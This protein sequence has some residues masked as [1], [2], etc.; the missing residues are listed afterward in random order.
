MRKSSFLDHIKRR[1]D[2]RQY[3]VISAIIYFNMDKIQKKWN[4]HEWKTFITCSWNENEKIPLVASHP[5]KN[6]V[7]FVSVTCWNIFSPQ[8]HC[9]DIAV[10][11]VSTRNVVLLG[12]HTGTKPNFPPDESSNANNTDDND[13]WIK[14]TINLSINLPLYYYVVM[15]VRL[16][17]TIK[18][19]LLTYL[20][21]YLQ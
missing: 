13:R 21:T 6:V 12:V 14:I 4:V 3:A 11:T 8:F 2:D 5:W 15:F 19:Y 20:L 18:G 10:A 9:C 17:L 7:F 1:H 16:S